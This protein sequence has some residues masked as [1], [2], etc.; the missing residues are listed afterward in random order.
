MTNTTLNLFILV[1]GIALAFAGSI[2]QMQT[3]S[4]ISCAFIGFGLGRFS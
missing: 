4:F 1:V 3:V 2:Y